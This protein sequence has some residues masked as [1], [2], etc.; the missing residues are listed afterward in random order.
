[1]NLFLAFGLGVVA[2]GLLDWFLEVKSGI[3]W[4]AFWSPI[5]DTSMHGKPWIKVHLVAHLIGGIAIALLLL[6]PI[7][8]L[9]F[10]WQR[11]VAILCFQVLW[12]RIQHENWKKG[13]GSSS[14][15]WWSFVWDVQITLV[16]WLLIEMTRWL[17]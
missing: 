5:R 14:Y 3:S 13:K 2:A 12:E 6:S 10:I 1:M 8:N 4:R 15:P 11:F 17:L 16:G 9:S 7:F